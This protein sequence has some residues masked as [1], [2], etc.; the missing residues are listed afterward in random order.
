[1]EEEPPNNIL[2]KDTAVVLEGVAISDEWMEYKNLI[3]FLQAKVCALFQKMCDDGLVN[4]INDK[5]VRFNQDVWSGKFEGMRPNKEK[6]PEGIY[7]KNELSLRHFKFQPQFQEIIFNHLNIKSLK[8]VD[9]SVLDA[10][11]W[12]VIERFKSYVKRNK[13]N[14]KKISLQ[15]N[16]ATYFKDGEIKIDI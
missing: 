14:A 10:H 15:G 3:D 7:P 1:M 5:Y 6:Y 12:Y 9:T 2:I 16:K 13:K 11:V 4:E 8:E